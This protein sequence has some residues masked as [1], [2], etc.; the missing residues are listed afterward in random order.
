MAAHDQFRYD[1][2]AVDPA[3]GTLTCRYSTATHAFVERF[4]FGPDRDWSGRAVE[5]AVRLLFL[6]AGVSYYKTTAAPTID[7]RGHPTTPAERAFLA[8]Y[9]AHGLG[10]FAYRNGLDLGSLRIVGPDARSRPPG[11]RMRRCASST[12]RVT[13]SRRLRTPQPSAGS[14]SCAS[15]A[16]SI[17]SSSGRV[18]WA[19]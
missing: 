3:S 15:A 5:E 19:S 10:E 2:F 13:A 4:T 11:N 9:F 14:L 16:R 12:H 18:S 6:V 17:R 7:L 8:A 1:G